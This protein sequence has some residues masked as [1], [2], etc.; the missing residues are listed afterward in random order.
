MKRNTCVLILAAG[1]A[2]RLR[3]LSYRIPKPLVDINGKTLLSR[4]VTVFKNGGFKNF[5]VLIGYKGNL[6]KTEALKHSDIEIDFVE[7]IELAGMADA[8]LSCLNYLDR[9]DVKYTD[10]FLTA[11]DIIFSSVEIN[12]MYSLFHDAKADLVLSLMKS[13]DPDIAKGHG[14]V[15]ITKSSNLSSDISAGKG[16]RIMDIIE[17]PKVEQILSDYYSP[18]LYLFNQKMKNYLEGIKISERGEKE[19]QDAI[20]R[21][22]DNG[23]IVLGINVVKELIT[24]E[25]IGEYHVTCLKD[26]IKMNNRF[27]NGLELEDHEGDFPTY[28]EPVKLNSGV[29]IGNDVLLGPNVIIRNNCEIKAN[30]ELSNTILYENVVLGGGC[31]L[32][33]CIV[34]AN[35]VLPEKFREKQCFMTKNEKNELEIINF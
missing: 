15:K 24:I 3:P 1:N 21:S 30:C 17:K 19:F 18:P 29:K 35:V 13:K 6:V 34:D 9:K 11:A 20:N 16:V 4:I 12:R 7:Q 23:D 33:W 32:N 31:K 26:I 5:C 10:F 2:T 25:N 14:N 8:V 27:L 28:I 22:I